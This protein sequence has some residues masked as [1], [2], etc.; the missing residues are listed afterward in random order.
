MRATEKEARVKMT[1]SRVHAKKP[2]DR[3]KLRGGEIGERKTGGE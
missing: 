1:R 2:N 3:I